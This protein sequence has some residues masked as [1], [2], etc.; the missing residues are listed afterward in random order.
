MYSYLYIV[1]FYIKLYIYIWIYYKELIY[2]LVGRLSKADFYK[3]DHQE[4]KIM[5]RMEH[6]GNNPNLCTRQNVS[7]LK[8]LHLRL[9]II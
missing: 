9:E 4:R 7:L 6:H 8:A 3:A 5:N 2:A 1:Y